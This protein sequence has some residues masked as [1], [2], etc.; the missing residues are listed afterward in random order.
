MQNRNVSGTQTK[1]LPGKVYGPH[2][3]V[4]YASTSAQQSVSSLGHYFH[5]PAKTLSTKLGL[6]AASYEL[7]AA[8]PT[9]LAYFGPH[10]SSR[11]KMWAAIAA[12]EEKLQA[13]LLDY[14][15]KRE[16]VAVYGERSAD[17]ALRVPV[18][19]FS[20]RGRSS[21][22]VAEQV[23]TYS[24]FGKRWGH[25]YSKRLLDEV[26]GLGEEAVVRVSMVHYN[27][28]EYCILQRA[29]LG[30]LCRLGEGIW[31]MGDS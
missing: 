7:V 11:R 18:V 23:D 17:Q 14:L 21:R 30:Q 16:D 31:Y 8:I 24:D 15:N 6:A 28:A 4:L 13:I 10:A 2:I 12:H 3:A 29:P 5:N 27:T 19:S 26:L 9:L 25:F 1:Y 20:V 22:E